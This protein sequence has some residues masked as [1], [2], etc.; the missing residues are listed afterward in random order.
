[1]TVNAIREDRI[2]ELQ[3]RVEMAHGDFKNQAK[4]L[5]N[6]FQDQYNELS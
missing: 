5:E 4:W 6:H 3:K 2:N 1:M